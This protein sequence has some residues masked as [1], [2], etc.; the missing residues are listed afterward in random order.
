MAVGS[1]RFVLVPGFAPFF[2]FVVCGASVDVVAAVV[3]VSPVVVVAAVVVVAVLVV[4]AA[5]VVVAALVVV[6]A[7]VVVVLS[8]TTW[9]TGT[10]AV[11]AGSEGAAC[12]NAVA[13]IASTSVTM[14]V[15]T[16]AFRLPSDE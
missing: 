7:A 5:V 13:G 10:N 6:A 15:P 14:I 16:P 12:A 1:G 3:V 8:G 4:V 2:T 11:G 9:T